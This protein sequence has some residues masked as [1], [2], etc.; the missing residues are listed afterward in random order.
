MALKCS[1]KYLSR[2]GVSTVFPE[3]YGYIVRLWVV[4]ADAGDVLFR[5]TNDRC[6]GLFRMISTLIFGSGKLVSE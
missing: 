4:R 1:V 2:H 5:A 3:R 6:I